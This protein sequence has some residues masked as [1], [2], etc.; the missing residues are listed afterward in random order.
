L[1]LSGMGQFFG[2]KKETF[3]KMS[4]FYMSFLQADIMQDHFPLHLIIKGL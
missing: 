2:N 1:A 3:G 4:L